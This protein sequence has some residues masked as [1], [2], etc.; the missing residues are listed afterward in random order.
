MSLRP[1]PASALRAGLADVASLGGYF[2][3]GDCVADP[4]P[5]RGVATLYDSG[6]GLLDDI[7]EATG[8]RLRHHERRVAASIVHQGFAARLLSPQLGA[9]ALRGWVVDLPARRTRWRL[10][11]RHSLALAACEARAW[12]GPPDALL[13]YLLDDAFHEHLLPLEHALRSSA[14][15]P[16][17]LLRGNVASVI[18]NGFRLLEPRLGAGWRDLTRIALDHRYLRGQGT[19]RDRPPPFVRRSC[20]LYYRVPGGGVCGDCVLAARPEDRGPPM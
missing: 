5:W 15:L 1:V 18:A 8:R 12:Q 10:L 4:G 13:A 9:I 14:K 6:T 16:D 11:D 7:V 3:L 19:L 17:G 20:C 2:R